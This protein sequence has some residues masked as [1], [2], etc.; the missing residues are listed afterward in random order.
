[1][2]EADVV[3]IGA[4]PAGATAALNRAPLRRVSVVDRLAEPADRIGESLAP[5]ARR[6]L[7]DMGLW[8]EFVADGHLPW[9]AARSVWGTENSSERDSLA[10]LDGNGWHLDRRRFE[11]RL[12]SAAV[13]RG[14]ALLAPARPID[15][16]HAAAGWTLTLKYRDRALSVKARMILDCAGEQL[17]RK[18]R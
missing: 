12:R 4:G 9:F 17:R 3:I 11:A 15:L 13:A 7:G 6:L 10:D 1:M 14:A 16:T 5:A 8:A 2:L 18:S